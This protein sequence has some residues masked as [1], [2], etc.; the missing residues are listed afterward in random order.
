[1]PAEVCIEPVP[2]LP[3]PEGLLSSRTTGRIVNQRSI[4]LPSQ[5]GSDVGN[6]FTTD[7]QA[8]EKAHMETIVAGVADR[9][10]TDGPPDSHHAGQALQIPGQRPFP[11]ESTPCK[12]RRET[13]TQMAHQYS[14][15]SCRDQPTKLSQGLAEPLFMRA[16]WKTQRVQVACVWPIHMSEIGGPQPPSGRKCIIE[17]KHV[18]ESG[19]SCP[20]VT[21]TLGGLRLPTAYPRRPRVLRSNTTASTESLRPR[22]GSCK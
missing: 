9:V 12:E 18:T 6:A 1:M 16:H 7:T 13:C 10:L 2:A 14:N 11:R 17:E 3:D 5:L 21:K 19:M 4:H 20:Q 22:S 15:E 8:E